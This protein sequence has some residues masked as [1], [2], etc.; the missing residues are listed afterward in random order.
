MS[1]CLIILPS[2]FGLLLFLTHSAAAQQGFQP[3]H[4]ETVILI[5]KETGEVLYD[6][7]SEQQMYPASI[8]KI[9]T[10]IV[11]IEEGNLDDVVTVSQKA[12]EVIGTRVYL[13]KDEQIS[14]LKL[15]KGLLIN[16]GNDAGTAI[17]EHMDG[18]EEKFSNRMT[19]FAKRIGAT[20]SNFTNPHGLYHENHYTTAKDMAIITQYAMSNDIFR[21]IV[22]TKEMKWEGQEWQTILYNHHRLLW[23]YEGTTG[24]KNGF[25]RK[26]GY[27]LVTSA[28]KDKMKLIAVTL[29]S[30]S[31]R[32]AYADTKKLLDYGFNN[33]V[34]NLI[35][36]GRKYHTED[37][38]SYEITED[39]LYTSNKE[40][41]IREFVSIDG[42]L[43][44]TIEDDSTILR[45]QLYQE[46]NEPKEVVE[47]F[48][49]VPKEEIKVVKENIS[50]NKFWYRVKR[51]FFSLLN[52]KEESSKATEYI[53]HKHGRIEFFD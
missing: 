6:L 23:D 8:T 49:E 46:R 32:H 9:I 45:K 26:S 11:A 1:R 27:T 44:V 5:N 33:Y 39:I 13:V 43:T 38:R 4:S 48:S 47:V 17:A 14:L 53:I 28:S 3:F 16:S 34:T 18:N 25:V 40:S 29:N 24:V 51:M 19:E 50:E 15:V 2:V 31:S 41:K 37:G 22:G 20:N 35:P 10:G 30:P 12:T 7:N 42:V 52:I 36:K 21:E